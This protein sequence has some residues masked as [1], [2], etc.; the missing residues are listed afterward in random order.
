MLAGSCKIVSK[1]TTISCKAGEL[2]FIPKNLS[3][4]S[5]WY[6]EDI[7][8]FISLGFLGLGT[9]DD[10]NYELQVIPCDS[11]L[12]DKVLAI[13]MADQR[14]SCKILSAFYDVMSEVLPLLRYSAGR[15]EYIVET[16]QRYICDNIGCGIP[17]IAKACRISEPYLYVI[18]KRRMNITPNDFKQQILVKKGMELLM[19]T[20]K[21][22]EE[23]ST[24]LGFSS[25]SYFRK[26]MKKHTGTT[27][28]EIRREGVV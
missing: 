11:S 24:D 15:D 5:Y 22:V 7:V 25:A 6:G 23:I 18:F 4:E 8:E 1:S 9:D 27:P 19:T 13:S 10:M 16:A 2:F 20:D 14:P 26:V 3:Y 12:R 17:D 21:T 28:R